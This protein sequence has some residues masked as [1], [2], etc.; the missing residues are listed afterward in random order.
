MA[1][2]KT[3]SA[4]FRM[5]KR[6][7]RETQRKGFWIP[8]DIALELSIYCAQNRTDESEVVSMLL[9]EHLNDVQGR[10]GSKRLVP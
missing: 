4:N 1:K 10:K 8:A 7:K 5:R 3:D 6:D 9:A 2:E